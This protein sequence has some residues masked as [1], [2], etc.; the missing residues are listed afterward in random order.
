MED[1]V[2]FNKIF[3]GVYSGKRVLV[4]GH[5]GFKG[6]WLAHWLTMMGAE[7]LGIA[8]APETKPSHFELLESNYPS[9]F[10]DIN[11]E[12]SLKNEIISFSPEFIFHLAAQSLVRRSYKEPID[13]LNTNIIGTAH[14]Y[15]IA[16]DCKDLRV[17]INITTDKVY[18]NREEKHLYEEFEPLGGFD[19]YS[20]S[21]ACSEIV[22]SSMQRSFFPKSNYGISHNVLCATMR[23][24]NV[25]GG[26]DWCDDRLIPDIVRAARKNE[27][28]S[29]RNP[30]SVRP[31]QHVLDALSAYLLIGQQLFQRN[32]DKAGAW[33]IG[34]NKEQDLT[35]Q[36]VLDIAVESWTKISYHIEKDE[37]NF[38]ESTLLMLDTTKANQ[39]LKWN[40]VWSG[41]ES[42]EKTIHWYKIFY[43]TNKLNTE[44]DIRHYIRD[45]K[46]KNAIWV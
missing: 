29:I 7:V 3:D 16:R 40:P 15:N 43:D 23:A 41:T 35:V 26:G 4:S 14:I 36:N 17:L 18:E 39:E 21:K 13:T 34:P 27:S 24:G 37:S 12:A 10:I 1:L 5:T 38:H 20:A 42:I 2:D 25:I 44:D 32:V 11:D 28:T 19:P 30:E 31:W 45:A 8:L 46:S 6:S 22:S 33:N 9:K